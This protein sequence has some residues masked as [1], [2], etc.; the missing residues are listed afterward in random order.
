M[1]EIKKLW[2]WCLTIPLI[3][4]AFGLSTF[5]TGTNSVYFAP[6]L[7]MLLGFGLIAIFPRVLHKL[8]FPQNKLGIMLGAYALYI[9]IS[10]SWSTIPYLSTQF[11]LFFCVTPFMLFVMMQSGDMYKWSRNHT[12]AM[13]AVF[14]GL[15]VWAMIQYIFLFDQVTSKRVHH[16]MLNPNSLA[17]LFNMSLIAAVALFIWARKRVYLVASFLL[18]ALLYAGLI[19]TQSR[20][21][22]IFEAAAVLVLLTVMWRYPSLTYRKLGLMAAVLVL[23]PLLMDVIQPEALEKNITKFNHP[24]T[25]NSMNSRYALIHGTWEMI[26]DYP[27]LG[28]GLS[29]FYF[30]YPK[31]R[32]PNDISDGF[33][34]HV[35]PMQFWAEMGILAP[36]LFYGILIA[37]LLRTIK[38]V[39]SQPKDS[40]L[41]LEIMMTFCALLV[42]AMHAHMTFHLYILA[43]L[44]PVSIL[45]AY[46][47]AATE[48]ALGTE[49]RLTIAYDGK[50]N[51][52]KKILVLTCVIGVFAG[53]AQWVARAGLGVHL[54]SQAVAS[55][56]DNNYQNAKLIL[57]QAARIAP[58]NYYRMHQMQANLA[59]NLLSQ[60]QN[61]LS[62]P[63][64]K[65]LYEEA[66]LHLKRAQSHAT[67]FQSLYS[68]EAK[69][70]YMVDGV[71][72]DDG[73]EKSEKIL[74]E[75]IENNPMLW[76]A[77]IGLARIYKK[78]GY[79]K[80][81]V[82]ILEG[83]RKWPMPKGPY[84][85]EIFLEMARLYQRMGDTE[86]AR[87]LLAEA[88]RWS[89]R[90]NRQR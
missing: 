63:E 28:T 47:Y 52:F 22:V 90:Y 79:L 58:Q 82:T 76:D 38:A 69:L 7:L 9:L 27:W 19:A 33:F 35:D 16:P 25:Y 21:G 18:M 44:I 86:N 87:R 37:V 34:V 50:D 89:Q 77:R 41:R 70:Y 17:G 26:K 59:I 13:L 64:K 49:D 15:A 51:R 42:I 30:F 43:M 56:N 54:T 71:F 81:A 72:L 84:M 74:L 1:L 46:W 67:H 6:V 62:R 83:G 45:F 57:D 48:K 5:F 8:E 40:D 66:L 2:P 14:A 11:A 65:A 75:V 68:E 80:K 78:Q 60:L 4:A 20:A 73:L 23:V 39:R 55:L 10:I 3:V 24:S 32:L 12:L 61:K 53:T 31:Y 88:N 29:T 85:V 36:I